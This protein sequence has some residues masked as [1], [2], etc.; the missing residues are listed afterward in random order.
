MRPSDYLTID[1]CISMCSSRYEAQGKFGGQERY[2]RNAQGI[3]VGL[4]MPWKV[5]TTMIL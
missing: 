3:A 4:T 5:R 2:V 1:S